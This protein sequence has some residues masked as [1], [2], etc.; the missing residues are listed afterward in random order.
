[1]EFGAVLQTNP[2]ASRTVHLAKLA[3]QHGF[4]YVWTF[5]SHLLWQ[6]PY[7]IYSQILNET[8]RVKVGPMVTNP[9][10]RDWTVTASLYATL[11]EMYGNR[12]IMGIGRGDSAVRVTNGAPTTL[13]ALRE[14]IH[15]IRELANSR[16]VEY[17]GA[18]LRFPWSVGSELDVWVA[19]Y[20]P[21]ALKL[22]GEVGDGFILQ[23]ADLDIAEWMIKTV[24]AA[25]E[26]VG[27]D[28]DEIAFCVAA[29][30][31]IGDDWQ[32]MRDQ[33]RWF[34]GMVGNHVAD[35][36]S[37]YGSD[38]QVPSALT[39]YIKDREGYDYNEHGRAGNSHTAFVPDEIVDRFC[40]L[41]TAD[42]H[43]EKLKRLKDIGVT[44]FAG[45]LQHDNKEE[46][47]RVYGETVIPALKEHIT[48]KA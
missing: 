6:E 33:C 42:D 43:I 15:V 38:S 48:A 10:T 17:N 21:L 20:G 47:L 22:T 31:Y 36:V 29:P 37:K 35:I 8:H 39:D 25:A 40:L 19:A 14:S 44:Q 3:E 32:H 45:Y 28:P 26:N 2:P 5:D 11:N 46:T 16:P 18:E 23:L 7:V 4:E 12:T 13:K 34:G 27:R 41:G 9:A 1:M 24:R 30:M